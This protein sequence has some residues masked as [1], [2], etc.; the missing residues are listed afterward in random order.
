ME[1]GCEREIYT[2]KA[3]KA[4]RSLQEG[5]GVNACVGNGDIREGLRGSSARRKKN[6]ERE[7]ETHGNG[8]KV[9]SHVVGG[10]VDATRCCTV[11]VVKRCT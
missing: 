2:E 1:K 5:D 9:R 7:R 6:K 3:N 4:F 10:H 11:T 8:I